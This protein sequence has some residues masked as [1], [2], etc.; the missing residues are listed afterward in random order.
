[1]LHMYIDDSSFE[2]LHK[3]IKVLS[4]NPVGCGTRSV[5]AGGSDVEHGTTRTGRGCLPTL[6][7][8]EVVP[9]ALE[10]AV[11]RHMSRS[12]SSMCLI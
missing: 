10:P 3:S 11:S 6:K 7:P 4:Y 8:A 1:M 9:P 2:V 12:N 5:L